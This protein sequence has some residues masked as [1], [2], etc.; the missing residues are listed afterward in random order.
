[1]ATGEGPVVQEC[2]Q[3]LCERRVQQC[4]PAAPVLGVE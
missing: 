3:T 1:M 2:K 4:V